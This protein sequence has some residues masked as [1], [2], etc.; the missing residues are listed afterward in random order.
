MVSQQKV[1]K[2]NQKEPEYVP[3]IKILDIEELLYGIGYTRARKNV[4]KTIPDSAS[5]SDLIFSDLLK[6]R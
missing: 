2:M 5:A 4:G 6:H 3:V 1:P